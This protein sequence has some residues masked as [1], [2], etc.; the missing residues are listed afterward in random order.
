M[1]AAHDNCD[2][3]L[4]NQQMKLLWNSGYVHEV[5]L[6]QTRHSKVSQVLSYAESYLLP[7]HPN[8]AEALSSPVRQL[9]NN[10]RE[11]KAAES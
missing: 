1:E 5:F 9:I 4:H 7:A 11:K 8:S 10:P 6:I 2:M 3:Y